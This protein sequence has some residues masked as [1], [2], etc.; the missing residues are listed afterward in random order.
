VHTHTAHAHTYTYNRKYMHTTPPPPPPPPTHTRI[1][2]EGRS[3]QTRKH[4]S[5]HRPAHISHPIPQQHE[6]FQHP[7]MHRPTRTAALS[8][9]QGPSLSS[10]P[11]CL[12]YPQ[13]RCCNNIH[14]AQAVP[15]SPPP[16]HS[17][18]FCRNFSR[19][20]LTRN[21][22]RLTCTPPPEKECPDA[23]PSCAHVHTITHTH[24]HVHRTY[25]RKYCCT[26][27]RM[28]THT[29]IHT[30]VYQICMH[31]NSYLLHLAPASPDASL[32]ALLA[33][34]NAQAVAIATGSC[35][36][37]ACL[38]TV[39]Y[40]ASSASVDAKVGQLLRWMPCD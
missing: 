14:D 18:T 6:H 29:Q 3:T 32:Q 10:Q 37:R 19:I 30:H 25:S 13:V 12:W 20:R 4:T 11:R 39:V 9:W 24:T 35:M 27:A 15:T 40:L 8:T 1:H 36:H 28:H 2:T 31:S 38:S 5:T 26:Y 34:V 7:H 33:V 22:T 23:F 17:H 16:T 21:P